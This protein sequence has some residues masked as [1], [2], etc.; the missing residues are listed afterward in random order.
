M[1]TTKAVTV[2]LRDKG[3]GK[4]KKVAEIEVTQYDTLDEAVAAE[5]PERVL[6]YFNSQKLTNE[7]NAARDAARPDGSKKRFKE[8]AMSEILAE[9]REGQHADILGDPKAFEALVNQRA[10]AMLAE[11]QESLFA[12]LPDIETEEEDE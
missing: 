12:G 3:T 8:Q 5:G 1:A 7:R 9:V 6:S 2:G 4:N 10:D 11:A